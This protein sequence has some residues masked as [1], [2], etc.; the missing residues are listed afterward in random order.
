MTGFACGAVDPRVAKML[1]PSNNGELLLVGPEVGAQ[2][3]EMEED[4]GCEPVRVRGGGA[5]ADECAMGPVSGGG[6]VPPESSSCRRSAAVR[7]DGVAC[8]GWGRAIEGW[9]GD[10]GA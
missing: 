6:A 4:E 10:L 2:M 3:L 5:G 1:P 8:T 9:S 7:G